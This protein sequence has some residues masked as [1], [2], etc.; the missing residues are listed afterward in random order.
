MTTTHPTET[1]EVN[2][3]KN[4]DDLIR[5]G[6]SE[7]RAIVLNIADRVLRPLGRLPPDQGNHPPRR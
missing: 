7:S 5:L 2:K 1:T 3:I 4:Y 6:D